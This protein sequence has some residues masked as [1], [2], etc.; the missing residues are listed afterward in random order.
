MENTATHFLKVATLPLEEQIK[1]CA[2]K[3]ELDPSQAY[4]N[5]KNL[6]NLKN[7]TPPEITPNIQWFAIPYIDEIHCDYMGILEDYNIQIFRCRSLYFA[8]NVNK[9]VMQIYKRIF[10]EQQ[11]CILLIPVVFYRNQFTE[12]HK[13]ATWLDMFAFLSIN[14][15]NQNLT[16]NNFFL[17]NNKS[18]LPFGN[19]VCIDLS[20]GGG[21]GG[22]TFNPRLET[23][24]QDL[25]YAQLFCPYHIKKIKL[26]IGQATYFE[27]L[28][29]Y[30]KTT[31]GVFKDTFEHYFD[32][33]VEGY[34]TEE[35]DEFKKW[36]IE[37][38]NL[39]EVQD[40]LFKNKEIL[41][42]N[43]ERLIREINRKNRQLERESIQN[44]LRWIFTAVNNPEELPFYTKQG[45]FD[46]D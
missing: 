20:F 6:E 46:N 10:E 5:A 1:I 36:Y 23:N 13:N 34:S 41:Q 11:S 4:E 40:I 18:E 24:K 42:R 29:A 19:Y 30:I 17:A 45:L 9:E 12:S 25:L 15:I 14:L 28:D 37:N 32:E 8:P 26:K 39:K 31:T 35:R 22:P 27:I 43:Y 7:F 38:Y 33:V 21:G 2:E 16:G 44:E 3:F